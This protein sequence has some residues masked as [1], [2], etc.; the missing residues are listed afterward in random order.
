MSSI[1]RIHDENANNNDGFLLS[2][3][4]NNA[5]NSVN[6]NVNNVAPSNSVQDQK[7]YRLIDILMP[8]DGS[9]RCFGCRWSLSCIGFTFLWTALSSAGISLGFLYYSQKHCQ[10]LSIP[11]LLVMGGILGFMQFYCK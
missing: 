6:V 2:S 7:L 10:D 1:I 4:A 9:P 3:N 5:N 11:I 8:T